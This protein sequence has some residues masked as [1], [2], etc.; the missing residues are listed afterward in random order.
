MRPKLIKICGITRSIDAQESIDSGADA[1]GFIFHPPSPRYVS[2]KK[3]NSLQNEI[4]FS[5]CLKVAVAVSPEPSLVNQFLEAGFD[6]FQFH[7]PNDFPIDK[8]RVWS[9]KVGVENLWLAPRLQ[10]SEKFPAEYLKF[11]QT[12]LFDAY[13]G[14][15]FGGTGN[16]SDWTKFTQ[17][18]NHFSD[19]QWYLAGGLSAEN[20]KKVM[21]EVKPD[22]VDLNSGVESSPGVKDSVKLKKVFSI[23]RKL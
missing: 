3:F 6:K 2:L 5:G 7:F 4:K 16:L 14:Q 1:L 18:K 23:L 13:S 10:S 22:G 20:I 8:I 19:K 15:A 9:Q 21:V 12:I 11:A 17:L